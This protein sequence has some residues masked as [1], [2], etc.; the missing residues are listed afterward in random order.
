VIQLN[1]ERYWL[2]AAVDPDSNG[3]LYTKLEA[4]RNNV[5]GVKFFAELREKHDVDDAVFLVNSAPQ[6]HEVCNCH[7]LNF[8]FVCAG[9]RNS[10]ECVFREIKHR[11]SHFSYCFSN[12][13]RE[14]ADEW[15]R[16]FAFA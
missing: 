5:F 3:L 11:T 6:L 10:V 8:Q 1:N 4:T 7:G 12:A 14:T 15:L 16:H 13:A 9:N 2:Y